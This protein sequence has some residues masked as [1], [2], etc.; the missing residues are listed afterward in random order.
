MTRVHIDSFQ[1][2]DTVT[3]KTRYEDLRAQIVRAGKFSVFEATAN[4][5]SAGM[6]TRLCR[7][8][9]LVIDHENYSYPWTGVRLKAEAL[10]GEA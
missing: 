8:P 7:D 4:N 3:R 2:G 1:S 5:I 10:K 9:E 6:F